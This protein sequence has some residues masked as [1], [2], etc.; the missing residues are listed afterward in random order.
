MKLSELNRFF[1]L[2]SLF[3][4]AWITPSASPIG[5]ASGEL[6]ARW[7]F[8]PCGQ[9]SIAYDL[10]HWRELLRHRRFEAPMLLT[11]TSPLVVLL[12]L[13]VAP[14][15]AIT[16]VLCITR[17]SKLQ[18]RFYAWGLRKRL[19]GLRRDHYRDRGIEPS[20]SLLIRQTTEEAWLLVIG[21]WAGA[22]SL[23][24]GPLSIQRRIDAA[25][26][27]LEILA[28]LTD[29]P[30]PE[31][32]DARKE[33]QTAGE[34][35]E[36]RWQYILLG[37]VA[38]ASLAAA[39]FSQ[40]VVPPFTHTLC[41]VI[42]AVVGFALGSVGAIFLVRNGAERDQPQ[43]FTPG[44]P[45]KSKSDTDGETL[46]GRP[47]APIRAINFSA[48]G[49]DT[50]MDLGVIHALV[51]IHGRAPD[52]V[53]G[54]SAG[55]IHAAGLAEVL[56]SGEQS[57]VAFL[58]KHGGWDML[59]P[60]QKEALQRIRL[61]AR[62]K[63][64]RDFIEAAQR[65]PER[66]ID[67][68]LPDAYQIDAR[69]P[70]SPLQLPR[71]APEERRDRNEFLIA[72]SG[73][74]QLYNDILDVP[75]SIGT[76]TRILR[77][78]L[79]LMA[80]PEIP[81][82]AQ[83]WA[84]Y[85]SESV[86]LWLLLGINLV[87][88]SRVA[89]ILLR[90]LITYRFR[91]AP[92]TA[93]ALIFRSRMFG[94]I[95]RFSFF[96]A[97]LVALLVVWVSFSIV[98]LPL[99]VVFAFA[100][101]PMLWVGIYSER[102]DPA[103]RLVLK[104]GLVAVIRWLVLTS[105][106]TILFAVAVMRLGPFGH[107]SLRQIFAIVFSHPLLVW[108]SGVIV[109]TLFALGAIIGVRNIRSNTRPFGEKLLDSY[110]LGGSIFREH[111]LRTLLSELF[112]PTYYDKAA[113]DDAVEAALAMQTTCAPSVVEANRA[114]DKPIA[115]YSSEQRL[116]HERI[117]IGLGV[118]NTENGSLDVVPS[119]ALL[120]DGLMAATAVTPL[121]PPVALD[122]KLPN[123]RVRKVLFIDG[124]NVSRESTR[125][126]FKLLREKKCMDAGIVQIYSVTPFPISKP[127]GGMTPSQGQSVD[128]PC[129][130][131]IE[132]VRRALRLRRFRDAS[133]ERRLTELVTTVIPENHPRIE[134]EPGSVFQRAWVTPI[135]LDYDADVNRRLYGAAKTERRQ[136]IEETISDGCRAALQVMIPHAIRMEG[137][138]P[139]CA[140]A[141]RRHLENSQAEPKI[142]A[143]DLPGSNPSY[144]PGLSDICKRCRLNRRTD[145]P[146]ESQR[147][148][149]GEWE[150]IG[151]SWPHERQT[152]DTAL[153]TGERF[154]APA[155][156]ERAEL[157]QA[158][159]KFRD[160]GSHP[161]WPR[162]ATDGTPGT[163]RSTVSLLF[164]GGVFR[165]VYQLGVLNGLNELGLKPDLIAGASIGAITAAM[166]AQTFSIPDPDRR[167]LRIARLAGAYL[168][169]DRIVLT[170]RFADF[171]RN[172]TLRAAE[173]RFSIRQIDRVFRKFD[174]PTLLEFDRNV[175]RV[176]AGIERLLYV[177]PYQLN[178]IVRAFR[179]RD[180]SAVAKLLEQSVQQFLDRMGIGVEALGSD[181]LGQL[182]NSYVLGT[183]EAGRAVFT[184]DDLRRRGDIQFLATTTNLTQGRLEVLG[185]RPASLEKPAAG[186]EEALLASSAF[187][188]VF[189]PRWSWE[190]FSTSA[191]V[192]QYIDGGVIDNL[193]VDAIAG[194]LKRAGRLNIIE[195]YPRTP[196]LIVGAS[197]EVSAPSY[198]LAFTRRRFQRSWIALQRRAKQLGYNTKLD[199]YE[200][201][202]RSLRTI[203]EFARRD[204]PD[205][206]SRERKPVGIH[207][208]AI[209]PNWLCGT[210]AFHPMLGFR[211]INQARSI[212]HGCATTL[213][214]FS[215]LNDGETKPY[216]AAW[217]VSETDIPSAKSWT[218]A[219]EGIDPARQEIEAGR[220][221][222]TKKACPFSET[223]MKKNR[224]TLKNSGD[225]NDLRLPSDKFIVEVSKIHRV[226]S[227]QSTH[228]RKL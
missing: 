32:G 55:A 218:T 56:Q 187:P 196:H 50:L 119:D 193:P 31:R 165:G 148:K 138:Q 162:N 41:T 81:A 170:D 79:A 223:S 151:P 121:F 59:Q 30:S 102:L 176:A 47:G 152:A 189:R 29:A 210:F 227:L 164:S 226:C 103:N 82:T 190:L 221:W 37:I 100:A 75:F 105:I 46:I 205:A 191:S 222:L 169:I 66:L 144:G 99:A 15:V 143:L 135:E 145:D 92:G 51:V 54:L 157:E 96:V 80:A 183:L 209:K 154:K 33:L 6:S 93:G 52:V 44:P 45:T 140:L 28:D 14:I 48:G 25:L 180:I 112:D 130:N 199:T 43:H 34:Q 211:R 147:L 161:P 84:V 133:L 62:V 216:L 150:S 67:S 177:S 110:E 184:T 113:T 214:R 27:D 86:Q 107:N 207:L 141:V 61:L 95:T 158:W 3:V 2:M 201:A 35:L 70:L 111:G 39:T 225:E 21:S 19:I 173:T 132:I 64:L 71:F 149:L 126:L 127:E 91:A 192:E 156:A 9:S 155:P 98:I 174:Q 181:A 17:L 40:N 195:P 146:K 219:F 172:L 134:P 200:F 68:V 129:L 78:T 136:I 197:L 179:T 163:K 53:T 60:H 42:S 69:R 58:K 160:D 139:K 128:G 26:S 203:H 171:V 168:S 122:T 217:G 18:A 63:R 108:I 87:P 88:A 142:A 202:E 38:L 57:E 76:L 24:R 90:A 49:F 166:I 20:R 182:I 123:G 73:L 97:T 94:A 116:P 212:A 175:R 89:Q 74:A 213:M 72:R 115:H 83:R 7:F 118:A 101:V 186:L 4:A 194:F 77:R 204:N 104:N 224:D 12:R 65:A 137:G 8:L 36:H 109:A 114:P 188:G 208:L 120:V 131:L 11:C 167:R 220:C 215:Q 125:A 22:P 185:E 1:D 124:A 13:A 5:L 178:E 198:S 85:L 117:H 23:P 228:L 159:A 10:Q 153:Q 16:L 206:T 106:F